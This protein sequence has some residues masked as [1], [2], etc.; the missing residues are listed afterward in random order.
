MSISFTELGRHEAWLRL[1]SIVKA[2][3]PHIRLERKLTS[4]LIKQWRESYEAVLKELFRHIPAEVSQSAIKKITD[5]L[6]GALGTEFGNSPG[7]R[8]ELRK[9][10]TRAYEGGKSQFVARENLTLADRRAIE[11]LTRNNC[12]WLG[13]HYG[14]HIGPKIAE[15]TQDALR[16]GLGRK[17]LA[18]QLR[19]AL[20]G[21]V[22]GYRYWDVVSS[23]AL[24]RSRSFGCI[25]GMVEA[26]ITEYEILAMGDERMC[27][28]CGEL[29]GQTFSVTETQKVIE[30]TLDI[31]NPDDFK[32][33]MPWHSEPPTG[34]SKDALIAEGMS[35]PP[36]HGRCRCVLVAS[37][38]AEP[39]SEDIEGR[40]AEVREQELALTR[41]IAE[42][43]RRQ[44]DAINREDF[45]T[46]SECVAR[47][48]KLEE[49][50]RNMWPEIKEM[51]LRAAER[52]IIYASGL[53][54][55]LSEGDLT[56]LIER[57]KNA[58]EEIRKVWN[59]SEDRLSIINAHSREN[60]YSP[61]ERGVYID[62]T[63]DRYRTV[64]PAFS[65]I[66][67]ELGHLIDNRT[68][69]TGLFRSISQN[70]GYGL[71]DTLKSE[72]EECITSRQQQLRAEAV[73]AGRSAKDIKKKDAYDSLDYEL[74]HLPE[75]KGK[76]MCISDMFSGI[77]LNKCKGGYEHDRKYW[78]E[79]PK[80]VC[81]EFFAQM[82]SDLAVNPEGLEI[83]RRYAPK[84][85]AIFRKMLEDIIEKE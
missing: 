37:E 2:G 57:V 27:P 64:R 9:Y 12:Y 49:Q 51:R 34:K 50:F 65:G 31:E 69:A 6:A 36:F 80:L 52:G 35:V 41:E 15:L 71:F 1:S 81:E 84:S 63:E 40:I 39:S 21:Q 72:I 22:G 17:E 8:D 74:H 23:A 66:F 18:K 10:I 61:R 83:T 24:V 85:C 4:E 26:K 56:A 28:I 79:D 82:F 3:D 60:Y 5:S 58:P 78:R 45:D 16:D 77:T 67:H 62:F 54:G 55:S 30:R 43:N 42:L 53:D 70:T 20:G 29:S 44:E 38:T 48:N 76:N 47:R 68:R 32:A 13:E 7:V 75:G 33:A 11:V 73:L 19:G 14:K 46:V 25:S 59:L